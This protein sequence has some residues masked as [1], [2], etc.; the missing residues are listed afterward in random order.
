[1]SSCNWAE[2]FKDVKGKN[3]FL[4][5]ERWVTWWCSTAISSWLPCQRTDV[6]LITLSNGCDFSSHSYPLGKLLLW[7]SS[8]IW[9]HF[10]TLWFQRGRAS[11][12][13]PG[14][15]ICLCCRQPTTTWSS[16]SLGLG[17]GQKNHVDSQCPNLLSQVSIWL[18]SI[19]KEQIYCFIFIFFQNALP[20]LIEMGTNLIL[21]FY[22]ITMKHII[23][24]PNTT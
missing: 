9:L 20:F 7:F 13:F 3:V 21:E 24:I 19:T 17:V 6:Y 23:N 14:W 22:I 2:E 5:Q 11:G 18:I 10:L 8:A 1:M 15:S 4:F 16:E 12:E